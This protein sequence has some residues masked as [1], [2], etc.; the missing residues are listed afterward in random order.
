M[1]DI[2]QKPLS[3]STKNS[4]DQCRSKTLVDVDQKMALEDINWDKNPN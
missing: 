2:D 4:H 3:M 1:T